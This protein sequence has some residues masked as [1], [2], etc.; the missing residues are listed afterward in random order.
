MKMWEIHGVPTE[1]FSDPELR[2]EETL[3]DFDGPKIF[4]HQNQGRLHLFYESDVDD[5]VEAVRFIASPADH[6]LIAKLKSGA[7]SVYEALDQP[8]VFAL[9]V[10]F[11]WNIRSQFLLHEGIHGIPD[12]A[13]PEKKTLLW[14]SLEKRAQRELEDAGKHHTTWLQLQRE[15]DEFAHIP[16]KLLRAEVGKEQWMLAEDSVYASVRSEM[17]SYRDLLQTYSTFAEGIKKTLTALDVSRPLRQSSATAIDIAELRAE[18]MQ[19]T[20]YKKHS[21]RNFH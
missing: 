14:S 7:V 6:R 4:T 8:W 16:S 11:D 9:E 13:L 18:A 15:F 12:D 2:I 20:S 3:F 1:I 10:D 17:I 21:A 19:A 5:D